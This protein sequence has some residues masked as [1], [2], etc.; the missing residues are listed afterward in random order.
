MAKHTAIRL[1]NS[2]MT[3]AKTAAAMKIPSS[4]ITKEVF[5]YTETSTA[6]Y[7]EALLSYGQINHVLVESNL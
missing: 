5:F 6:V 7:V 2:L 4:W 1:E 3:A